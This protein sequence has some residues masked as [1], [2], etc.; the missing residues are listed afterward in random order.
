MVSQ[1]LIT[2]VNIDSEKGT[3]LTTT[4]TAFPSGIIDSLL[5]GWHLEFLHEFQDGQ[6]NLQAVGYCMH[7]AKPVYTDHV[8]A[9]K[10]WSLNKGGLC[11]QVKIYA[12]LV[13]KGRVK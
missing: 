7:T 2:I 10:K 9:T 12:L 4:T 8:W 1:V 11:I 5:V 3:P 6:L 13:F